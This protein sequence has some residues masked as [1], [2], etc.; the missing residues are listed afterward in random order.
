LALAVGAIVLTYQGGG[1][2]A[3]PPASY[4][5]DEVAWLRARLTAL[6]GGWS[7]A[8]TMPDPAAALRV[9]LHDRRAEELRYSAAELERRAV[10]AI[11]A[12]RDLGRVRG[13]AGAEVAALEEAVRRLALTLTAPE[14]RDLDTRQ[15]RVRSWFADLDARLAVAHDAAE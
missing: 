4:A 8:S 11:A 3:P 7:G 15:A 2:V 14:F 5:A 10:A 12:N 9:R 13:R 1:L 6:V